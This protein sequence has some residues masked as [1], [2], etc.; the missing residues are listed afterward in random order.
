MIRARAKPVN[1][2]AQTLSGAKENGRP[3]GA[4]V[5]VCLRKEEEIRERLPDLIREE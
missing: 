1:P 5:G 3:G 4:A 2:C